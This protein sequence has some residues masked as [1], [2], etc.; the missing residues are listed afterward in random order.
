MMAPD[1]ARTAS[2]RSV[3]TPSCPDCPWILLH[4]ANAHDVAFG[5]FGKSSASV[6]VSKCSATLSQW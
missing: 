2:A 1:P 5:P 6:V 4:C 3:L